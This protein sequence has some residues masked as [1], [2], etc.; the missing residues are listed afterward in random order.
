MLLNFCIITTVPLRFDALIVT[1]SNRASHH[2]LANSPRPKRVPPVP[3][4]HHHSLPTETF[5]LYRIDLAAGVGA[6]REEQD[7]LTYGPYLSAST[8]PTHLWPLFV[9]T[10][11]PNPKVRNAARCASTF[12]LAHLRMLKC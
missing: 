4:F 2:P 10:A 6:E 12:L 7:W 5:V 8:Q 11:I 3:Y 1:F 9:T